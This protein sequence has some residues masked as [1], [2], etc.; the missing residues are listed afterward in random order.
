MTNAKRWSY[1]TGTRGKNRVR[2]YEERSGLLLME[3]YERVDGQKRATRKRVSLG[4]HD[5]KRAMH[6]ADVTAARLGAGPTLGTA[7]ISL[8]SLFDI[9]EAEVTP[10]KTPGVQHHDRTAA[11]MFLA[12]WGRER[13]VSTLSLRDWEQF[14]DD[15]RAGRIGARGPV[16]DR[17][18]QYDLSWLRAVF[19]WATKAGIQG[20]PLLPRNPFQGYGVPRE[21]NP[22]RPVLTEEQYQVLCRAAQ[23]FDWRVGLALVF[24]NETGHRISAIRQVR[25]SDIDLEQDRILWR[26]VHDKIGYEHSTPISPTLHAALVAARMRS[27]AIGDAWVFPSKR[28]PERACPKGTLD[29]LFSAVVAQAK[30][31]LPLGARWHSLR[32]KFATELKDIPLKDLCDLGGWKDAK[33]VLS[34][35]QRPDELRMREALLARRPFRASP[36][37]VEGHPT[38]SLAKRQG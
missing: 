9:Y 36:L 5:R 4:H 16:G 8:G 15:R 30:I 24:A 1:S 32:R 13:P 26:A 12:Q 21:R 33:T 6:T 23:A 2:V 37:S 38:D 31:A 35:Y 18:I 29:H 28:H 17:Q 25:W 10:R 3:V 7:E 14:V 19:N 34:C 22:R 20:Q 27:P 11:Q